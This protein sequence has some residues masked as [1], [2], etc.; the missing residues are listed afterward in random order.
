MITSEKQT[1]TTIEVETEEV[2]QENNTTLDNNT[3]DNTEDQFSY[4]Q[5]AKNTKESERIVQYPVSVQKQVL[6]SIGTTTVSFLPLVVKF[7]NKKKDPNA[8][9]VTF[10]DVMDLLIYKVPDLYQILRRITYGKKS[11]KFVANLK[12]LAYG[13]TLT[14]TIRNIIMQY[15]KKGVCEID[16]E[17]LSHITVF[18]SEVIIPLI[19]NNDRV[20]SI[21][22]R[23]IGPGVKN[24]VLNNMINSSNPLIREIASAIPLSTLLFDKARYVYNSASHSIN[25]G[26]EGKDPIMNNNPLSSSNDKKDKTFADK[27]ID[28][29]GNAISNN[30]NKGYKYPYYDRYGTNNYGSYYNGTYGNNYGYNNQNPWS[31]N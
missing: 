27:L 26:E 6:I 29:V 25:K 23:I 24:F 19:A 9:P 20:Q 7:L 28:I 3:S 10:N 8:D 12:L 22:T 15:K 4:T 13:A 31:H 14:P 5:Y 1:K 2:K 30:N 18:A 11:E 16:A 21:F 17:L